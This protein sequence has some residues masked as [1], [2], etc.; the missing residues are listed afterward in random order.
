MYLFEREREWAHGWWEK[1]RERITKKTSCWMQSSTPGLSSP[2]SMRSQ[3]KLKQRIWCS[4]QWDTQPRLYILNH[5]YPIVTNSIWLH[6]KM[7]ISKSY[8]FT[9]YASNEAINRLTCHFCFIKILYKTLCRNSSECFL[10]SSV[11]AWRM[12]SF[13]WYFA[14]HRSYTW[15]LFPVGHFYLGIELDNSFGS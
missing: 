5:N 10:C 13:P 1:K 8:V 11:E 3:P 15:F 4:T 2:P 7:L 14:G 12:N 9:K 6:L